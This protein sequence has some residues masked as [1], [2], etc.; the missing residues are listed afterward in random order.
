MGKWKRAVLDERITHERELRESEQRAIAA[1]IEASEA[2]RDGSHAELVGRV[3]ANDT[4]I[5]GLER[6]RERQEGA[7]S[8]LRFIVF[9]LSIPGLLGALIALYNLVTVSHTP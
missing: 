2:R 7:Y 3:T 6:Q 8:T 1:S 5:T 9:V 4:R